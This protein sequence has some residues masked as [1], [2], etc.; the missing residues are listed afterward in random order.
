MS[1]QGAGL[2]QMD[3]LS[4]LSDAIDHVHDLRKRVEILENL[5][6]DF[7]DGYI[8]HKF[9]DHGKSSGN[10]LDVGDTE[11]ED[12]EDQN[13]SSTNRSSSER[14]DEVVRGDHQISNSSSSDWKLQ[15]VSF[16]HE[17]CFVLIFYILTLSL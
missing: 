4:I 1:S 12:T 17:S 6:N 15:E 3:K 11:N 9:I 14:L 16:K 13:N 2:L 7:G 5:N 10:D 8:D